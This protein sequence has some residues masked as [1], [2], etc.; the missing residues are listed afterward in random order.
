MTLIQVRYNFTCRDLLDFVH[1]KSP[2]DNLYI[3]NFSLGKVPPLK[4]RVA[5]VTM[6]YH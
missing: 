2:N 1:P 6:S 5:V 4:G 3:S